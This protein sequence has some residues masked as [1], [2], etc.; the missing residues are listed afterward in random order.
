MSVRR[1]DAETAEQYLTWALEE[2]EQF[3]YSKAAHHARIALDA[4]R[5]V[6]AEMPND[7]AEEAK[8][9]RDKADEAEQLAELADTASRRDVLAKIAKSYRRAAEHLDRTSKALA[10]AQSK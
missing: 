7:F 8:R 10:I 5:G 3:G 4:L 6:H 2:L 9:F 1:N